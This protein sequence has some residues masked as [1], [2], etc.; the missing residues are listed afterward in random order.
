MEK[1]PKLEI[2]ANDLEKVG[3]DASAIVAKASMV[4]DDRLW[5]WVSDDV[6]G[7]AMVGTPTTSSSSSDS[8]SSVMCLSLS[9]SSA[10]LTQFPL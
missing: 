1:V 5:D 10:V 4:E 6:R 9:P 2:C 7:S 8:V 3:L